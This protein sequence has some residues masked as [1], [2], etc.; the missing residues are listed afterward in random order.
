LI[1]KKESTVTKILAENGVGP[2]SSPPI[3]IIIS[4]E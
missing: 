2:A 3:K 1:L 4:N